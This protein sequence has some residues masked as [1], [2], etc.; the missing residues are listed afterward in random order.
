M[1]NKTGGQALRLVGDDLEGVDIKQFGVIALTY[2]ASIWDHM[3][4]VQALWI[5]G[6][7]NSSKDLR[8]DEMQA[9]GLVDNV[10]E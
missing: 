3:K 7:M 4:A 10:V 8:E 2:G 6:K 5:V 1:F 9:F